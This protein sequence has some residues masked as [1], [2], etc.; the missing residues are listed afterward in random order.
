MQACRFA[1]ESGEELI[2]EEIPRRLAHEAA[3]RREVMLD[4]LSLLSDE[5]AEA[6][7]AGHV[8]E[9]QIHAAVRQGVL[10][11]RLTPVFLGSAYKN[12]GVQ[13]LLDAVVRYLPS[14]REAFHEARLLENEEERSIPLSSAPGDE[15]VALAFKLEER[16]YGLLT[17]VR[18]YQGTLERGMTIHNAR[19][20]RGS[21]VG[22]LVRMHADQME[23]IESAAAGDIVAMLGVDC[24]SGDTLTGGSRI[25]LAAMHVPEPVVSLAV[26]AVE[27]QG[28]ERLAKALQRFAREDPTFRVQTDE[29]TGETLVRGMGELHLEVYLERIRREFGT[30]VQAGQP[31]VAYRETISDGAAFNYTHKKQTGGAGQFARVEGRLEPL[32]AEDFRFD[33]EIVGG[34]IPTQFI[35]SCEKG[36]RAA[37]SE[38]PY[39]GFPVV[40]VRAVLQD[41]AYHP[42]DSSDL[43]FQTACRAAFQHAYLRAEPLVLE[44]LML[45][46]VEGPREFQGDIIGSLMRCRGIIVGTTEEEGFLR[47]DA[48][49]PLAEMF[50]YATHL[51]SITQGKAEFTMEFAR[52]APAPAEVAETLVAEHAARRAAGRKGR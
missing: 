25:S 30:E 51:R 19:T 15:L 8:T 2:W 34:N 3:A 40:G 36:F 20:G 24:A 4:A 7:L 22:R 21:R 37:L 1:G 43:A 32:L 23:D 45:I 5:L 17:Y 47:I 50:G 41:G 27:R 28:E 44:P 13:L 35:P 18:I 12:K 39:A 52:Y 14:P 31:K 9:E 6:L 29:E 16:P 26:K 48:H 38:G 10:A 33:N 11:G 49:V 46:S 42:V